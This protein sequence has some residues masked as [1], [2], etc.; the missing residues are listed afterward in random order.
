MITT[1]V[2]LLRNSKKRFIPCIHLFAASS[3]IRSVIR[4]ASRINDTFSDISE[5]I[6]VIGHYYGYSSVVHVLN[7]YNSY[8]I[9]KRYQISIKRGLIRIKGASFFS[10]M[11][12]RD[13]RSNRINAVNKLFGFEL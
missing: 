4:T 2:H 11:T 9:V 10:Q 13:L 12:H 3:S 7:N 5:N 1:F 6:E 8:S